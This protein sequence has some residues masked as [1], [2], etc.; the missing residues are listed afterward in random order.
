MAAQ[1][2]RLKQLHLAHCPLTDRGMR[3]LLGQQLRAVSLFNC[4]R[5]TGA[6]LESINQTSDNLVSLS[7]V[8]TVYVEQHQQIFPV[9]LDSDN[10]EEDDFS[11]DDEMSEREENIYLKRRYI[12]RAPRLRSLTVRDLY[13]VQVRAVRVSALTI[14]ASIPRVGTIS[15]F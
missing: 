13:V 2:A 9:F 3:G 1:M 6:T 5:L 8:N 7:I 10:P 4:D 15:I 11:D 12:L 14:S